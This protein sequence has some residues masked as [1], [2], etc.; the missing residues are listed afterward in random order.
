MFLVM[1][2]IYHVVNNV[3]YG[4]L[5]LLKTVFDVFKMCQILANA[6]IQ[7]LK[8]SNFHIINFH[9]CCSDVAVFP[10]HV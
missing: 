7:L 3:W 5:I 9:M 6:L 1:N 8:L 4:Y 10:L 2:S